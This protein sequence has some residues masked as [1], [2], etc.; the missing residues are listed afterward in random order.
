MAESASFYTK[1]IF[2]EVAEEQLAVIVVLNSDSND[3]VGYGLVKLDQDVAWLQTV[4]VHSDHRKKGIGTMI[5]FRA[6]GLAASHQKKAV[7]LGVKKNNVEAIELYRKLG[8]C[9]V[10]EYEKNVWMMSLSTERNDEING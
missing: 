2:A 1:T 6:I 4:Y 5:V 9:I 7:S 10:W 8:F 3:I